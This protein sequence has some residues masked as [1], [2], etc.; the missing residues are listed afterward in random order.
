MWLLFFLLKVLLVVIIIVSAIVG[1]IYIEWYRRTF[2]GEAGKILQAYKRNKS[3]WKIVDYSFAHESGLLKLDWYYNRA[4]FRANVGDAFVEIELDDNQK[5]HLRHLRDIKL[6]AQRKEN[7]N[8]ALNA[9]LPPK[10]VPIGM[11]A[12]TQLSSKEAK[13]IKGLGEM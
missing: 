1:I 2:S 10:P 5:A 4:S 11:T 13:K 12:S 7:L 9:A 6:A 3:Q 8:A